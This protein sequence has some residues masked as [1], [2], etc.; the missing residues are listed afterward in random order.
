[1]AKA[2]D[3]L[4]GF[5][6]LAT[7]LKLMVKN[8]SLLVLSSVVG[9]IAF[10]VSVGGIYASVTHGGALVDWLLNAV[11]LSSMLDSNSWIRTA[12]DWLLQGIGVIVAI[13]VLPWLVA[14]IGFP[15]CIPLS[16][17]TDA[18]LGGRAAEHS[19]MTTVKLSLISI[20]L[21]TAVGL[22]VAMLLYLLSF[23]PVIG[24]VFGFTAS[25]I[26]TP[27]VLSYMVYENSLDRRGLSFGEKVAFVKRRLLASWSVGLQT[28]LFI[29]IPF[30]NLLGLP[31][32]VVAGAV[33]VRR[34]EESNIDSSEP[35]NKLDDTDSTAEKLALGDHNL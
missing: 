35:S 29:S 19:F 2:S 15:L 24:I 4:M 8:P 23:L 9:F 1:M 31:L 6:A 7:G 25:F 21:S 34:I 30:L 22:S 16:E 20:V 12:L 10:G 26:W 11:G 14:L 27:L 32:A 33:A 17:R 5:R 18:I 28:Q 13:V 3:M